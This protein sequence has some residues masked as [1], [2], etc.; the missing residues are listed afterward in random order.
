[1]WTVLLTSGTHN[2]KLMAATLIHCLHKSFIAKSY[3]LDTPVF[4]ILIQYNILQIFIL[5][6]KIHIYR[7]ATGD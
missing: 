4:S 6:N 3:T 5:I 7:L 2:V 1:M